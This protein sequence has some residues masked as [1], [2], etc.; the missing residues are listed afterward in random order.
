MQ[1]ESL[2]PWE[3][4]SEDDSLQIISSPSALS[5]IVHGV[6]MGLLGALFLALLVVATTLGIYAYYARA[7]PSPQELYQR[8]SPFKSTKIYDRHGRLLFEVFNPDS[9]RRTIVRY[10]QI[11]RLV[12]AAVV[13]TEDPTFFSN[14]GFNPFSIVRAA[15][16]N[17]RAGEVVSGASGITQQ[18]IKGLFLTSERNL[19]RKIK[20]AILAAEVTRRYS[21]TEILE[22]YLNEVSFG[23]MAY[24][25]GAAAETYFGKP[26]SQVDVAEA[27]L[28]AGML[29]SP[30]LYDPY[31]DPESALERRNI[32]LGLMQARGYLTKAEYESAIKQPLGVVPRTVLMEAPHMVMYVR[33]QLE[34]LYGTEVL[35][36]GGLQVYTTLDLDLQRLAEAIAKEKIAMLRE[37]GASNAA[38]IAMDPQAGD[39]LA[40]VGSVDF[41]DWA[42]DGQ[43]NVCRM[44][45]Q[46]GSTMKPFTYLAAMER[47]WTAATMV[48]DVQ[49]EFPDGQNPPYKPTNYDSKEWGPISLRTA[50]ACSRNI[51]AVSTLHQIGLPALL[52]VAHRLGMDSLNRDD[53]GLSLTL[54]GGEVTMLEL[55]DAYAA[56]ANGGHRITPRSILRIE[57]Q[58][59]NTIMSQ[60]IPESPQ[61][62]DPRHAYLLTDILADNAAR[63]LAFG[64]D[65]PLALPFP[66]AVKTGTTDDY[67][68]SW[69]VGYTPRLVTGVWVGNSNNAPMK[70]V[71]GSR[72]AALIWHD[73]MEKVLGSGPREEFIRPED[74]VEVEVCPVSGLK[75]TDACPPARKELFLK[76]NSPQLDC[77]VHR[78]LR[79]CSASGKLAIASCPPVNVQEV[80]LEDY[81]PAWDEWAR[82]K[83][84]KVP[85]RDTCPLHATP[86]QVRIEMP[87]GPLAGIV[88]VRGSADVADMVHYVVEYGIGPEP[89]GWGQVSPKITSAVI[90]G[91]LCSWDTRSLPNDTYA[92]RV[93]VADRQGNLYEARVVVQVQNLPPTLEATV[94]PMASVTPSPTAPHVPTATPEPTRTLEPSST[95]SLV[96]TTTGTPASTARP[97]PTR[98]A[99][100]ISGPLPTPPPT[101]GAQPTQDIFPSETLAPRRA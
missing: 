49:Q 38:L 74:L 83:G 60:D 65:S 72:G 27:A 8:V 70:R 44:P 87:S 20:E 6:G 18:L 85:P 17:F 73:F 7:L 42:I 41:D 55:T 45:R 2:S 101:V 66:V 61:V 77:T 48:M 24:G 4:L 30:T 93:V 5:I 22:V 34:R 96:A 26:L 56:L 12:I 79:I 62:M 33:E 51:P 23:N 86:V 31:A 84:L 13:A 82:Q 37:Q 3:P 47:G 57:D 29:Q 89:Q 90:D 54:G 71:S 67:R 64:P 32:V 88:E 98:G 99:T 11:P 36:K 14:P 16:Q 95:P 39:I 25:I 58:F 21:K 63:S 75:R 19:S 46:P 91:V 50:L 78:R 52:E 69:T 9:G 53:Y 15:Y 94:I 1:M 76:E 81:G 43:V 40:M 92:L 97:T 10:A 100:V 59:G 28:L 68:D 35:Y 80:A